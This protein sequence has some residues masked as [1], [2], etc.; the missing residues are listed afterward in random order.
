[1][2]VRFGFDINSK[3]PKL[4]VMDTITTGIKATGTSSGTGV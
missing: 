3:A 4:S 2:L 1:V